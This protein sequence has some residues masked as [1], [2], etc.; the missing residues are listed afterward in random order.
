MELD[1]YLAEYHPD[2]P[3]LKAYG[4]VPEGRALVLRRRLAGSIFAAFSLQ[5]AH[6]SL[7]VYD[8]DTPEKADYVPFQAAAADGPYVSLV[9]E[10]AQALLGDILQ[11]GFV[12]D[13]L[14]DQILAQ[15]R[16]EYGTEPC[17][18][19]AEYPG[20]CTLKA[21]NGKW[22]GLV[23]QVP[24]AVLGIGKAGRADVLNV[25]NLPEKIQA[26]VDGE[27]F[28]P[29]YHMNKKY[30]LSVLLDSPAVLPQAQVLLRES[31]ALVAGPGRR[32][33]RKR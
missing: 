12:R 32:S 13:S 18:P 17:F 29:A 26:L 4:F 5:G 21:P 25:K 22:Y 10:R 23:M 19:W 8:D 33:G 24:Y 3:R 14:R 27:H 28:L 20:H 2:R 6:F 9:R 30:W 31:Y 15:A 11:Q 1:R 16:Q 7:A